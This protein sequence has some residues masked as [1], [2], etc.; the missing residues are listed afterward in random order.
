VLGGAALHAHLHDA[1]VLA[2]RFDH[3]APLE[4]VVAGGLLDVD[5]LA[6]LEG[7]DGPQGVPVVAGGDR[8]RVDLLVLEHLPEVL[9]DL[10]FAPLQVVR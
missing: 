3:L 8:N 7:P 6:G 2:G 9:V 4:D 1:L 5:V 10:G